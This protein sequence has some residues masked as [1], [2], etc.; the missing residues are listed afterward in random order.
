VIYQ[1]VSSVAHADVSGLVE[2][3]DYSDKFDMGDLR[4][5]VIDSWM[6][7]SML[8]SMF[9][10]WRRA[11]RAHMAVRGRQW[12]GWHEALEPSEKIAQG[13]LLALATNSRPRRNRNEASR[14]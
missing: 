3:V 6:V 11:A 1:F 14:S 12:P 5:I 13:V 4:P 9:Y 7:H 2:M 8:L 10:G